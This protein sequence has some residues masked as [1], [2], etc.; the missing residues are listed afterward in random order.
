M[1]QGWLG[2][3]LQREEELLVTAGLG[4]KVRPW[5]RGMVCCQP[6]CSVQGGQRPAPVGFLRCITQLVLS[7][8]SA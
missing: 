8:W 4:P 7:P 3:C 1:L 5:L 6:G 2:L